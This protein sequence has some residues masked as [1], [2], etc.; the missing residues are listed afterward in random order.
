M[1]ANIHQEQ[2]DAALTL[3]PS[4]QRRIADYERAHWAANIDDPDTQK[5]WRVFLSKL[6]HKVES[7]TLNDDILMQMLKYL[8]T[9]DTASLLAQ[10]KKLSKSRQDRF[11]TLL[12]WVAEND[13]DDLQKEAASQIRERIL[14]TYRMKQFPKIFSPERIARATDVI[15]SN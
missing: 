14:M 3:S 7:N 2:V 10:I 5:L 8:S 9:L 6:K 15:Q 12:N 11:I 13:P 4:L 1:S